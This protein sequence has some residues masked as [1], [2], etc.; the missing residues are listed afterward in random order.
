MK[1]IKFTCPH[2]EAKLR[3]PTHLAGVSA[4]C[5][6]CG[7]TITAPSDITSAVIEAPTERRAPAAAA[8]ARA[9]QQSGGTAVL[10][11][12]VSRKTVATAP[13][14]MTPV[15]EIPSTSAAIVAAPAPVEAK[16]A[17]A[18]A[19]PQP[20][21]VPAAAPDS[22]ATTRAIPT[23]VPAMVEAPGS[24]STPSEFARTRPV[25][26]AA[27]TPVPPALFEPPAPVSEPVPAMEDER[28]APPAL[29]EDEAAVVVEELAQEMPPA[30]EPVSP[31]API[32]Q[33]I[34][35]S[36]PPGD[37]PIS[38]ENVSAPGT[39]P[40]LDVSLAGQDLS[41]A[42]AILFGDRATPQGRT[43]LVLPQPGTAVH[44]GSP[45]DFLVA[46]AAAASPVVAPAPPVVAVVPVPV[47]LAP[48]PLSGAPVHPWNE[49]NDDDQP[50]EVFAETPVDDFVESP[51]HDEPAMLEPVASVEP[52]LP[53]V[54]IPRYKTIPLPNETAPLSLDELEGVE[55]GEI[56]DDSAILENDAIFDPEGYLGEPAIDEWHETPIALGIPPLDLPE[57]HE[58]ETTPPPRPAPPI[59]PP[60][61]TDWPE[62]ETTPVAV[63]EGAPPG[64]P[65][66]GDDSDL[67]SHP[68]HGGSFG[69]LFLQQ[70]PPDQIAPGPLGAGAGLAPAAAVVPAEKQATLTPANGGDILDELFY[71]APKEA[72]EKKGLSKTAI[73]AISTVVGVAIF[74]I[75]GV[76]FVI[77]SFLGGFD[78][79]EAYREPEGGDPAAENQPAGTLVVKP[80]GVTV[81]GSVPEIEDAPAVIDPVAMLREETGAAPVDPPA[82]SFDEKVQQAVNG[83]RGG[84]NSLIGSPSLDLVE[85][86]VTDF[87]GAVPPALTSPGSAMTLPFADAAPAPAPAPAPTA[88]SATAPPTAPDAAGSADGGPGAAAPRSLDPAAS[89]DPNY[90]PPASFAAPGP[91]DGALGK[92]HDLIDAFLRAPD[93]A[94]RVNYAYQGDS[95][96]A[97]IEDY[98]KKWP[99]K[100]FGRYSLQLYQI[101]ADTSLGGP[102]WVFIVSTS[103]EEEGFPLIV[104]TEN[105]MLKVDWE[106]FAEFSDRHFLRFRDG[107]MPPP[108][109]FRVIVERFSDYYGSDKDA[110]TELK[111]HYVYQVNPP[112]GDLNEFSE[113]VF[114]KKDSPLAKQ[115][116]GLV[117]LGD[118]PL[119]V[120]VT[121]DNKAFAHGV[122]HFVITELLTEGW[123]H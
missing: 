44:A 110:F 81:P 37:L 29:L 25:A 9:R 65:T 111:D 36:P 31:L 102:Y 54:A 38:R 100:P 21:P 56:W 8:P 86:P 83:T 105:G 17:P 43:R 10:E 20:V 3:V 73:M 74:A 90:N 82:V 80:K 45:G 5:P 6:K 30:P 51:V 107:T 121:L 104:R 70:A 78:P 50:T 113:F 87:S 49:T 103:D 35:V 59:A 47:P 71:A 4:P 96:R 91:N 23:P 77:H 19:R 79:A 58:R 99:Y 46:P 24:V 75:V 92:T 22:P 106:I 60:F 33:P 34:R 42:G 55:S 66:L 123:F 112:Y 62:I 18:P 11:A 13:P 15:A 39:L 84:G 53:I 114:V 67:P 63:P 97:A 89:K 88:E 76:Y 48:P 32:T 7:A 85:T 120:V 122:K 68:L 117:R 28:S 27:P 109:T 116:D 72:G 115:L 14:V 69:R 93:W 16:S 40:R 108:A 12:P 26:A 52:E 57:G 1:K 61:P 119:A 95:L 94:T 64:L 41:G 118:E 2:C 98:H 101:E